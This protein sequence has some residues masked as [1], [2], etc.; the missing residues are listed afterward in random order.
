MNASALASGAVFLV[1]TFPAAAQVLS[2]KDSRAAYENLSFSLPELDN[3]KDAYMVIIEP[4]QGIDPLVLSLPPGSTGLRVQASLLPKASWQW[5]YRIV[6]ST[7]ATLATITPES[8]VLAR[9]KLVND[10]FLME[11]Q[12]VEGIKKY[13]ISGTSRTKTFARQDP[14]WVKFSTIE[15]NASVC[16]GRSIASVAIPA[17][18]GTELKLQVAAVD[19]DGVTVAKSPERAVTVETSWL[20]EATH[21]GFKLQRSDTL[22][23]AT[24]KLPA[25]FGYA[26]A[27]TESNPRARNYQAEFALLW[28]AP[29]ENS[30]GFYP[31]ATLEAHVTSSGDQKSSDAL[32]LRAGGYRLFNVGDRAEGIELTTNLKYETNHKNGTK[33]ALAEFVV[34]PIVGWLGKYWPGPPAGNVANSSGNYSNPPWAQFAPLLQFGVETGKTLDAGTSAETE[35]TLLRVRGNLRIDAEINRLAKFLSLK[36]VTWSTDLT[37]WRL[38]REDLRSQRLGRTVVSFGITPE[39]SFDLGHSVGHDAPDF[40][41]ARST[42][43]GLGIKF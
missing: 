13:Q 26:S 8:T 39:V 23:Q 11:W 12:P 41:F 28:E 2:M 29:A 34:V 6:R 1:A 43:A 37:Y 40:N 10:S 7:P 4:G 16:N 38:P 22:S 25:T 24:A 31:R 36:N 27:Q 30:W 35:K 19:N 20:Q 21:A 18:A 9:D 5:R 14:E 32:R 33:K 15:C 42:T 3:D 17:A